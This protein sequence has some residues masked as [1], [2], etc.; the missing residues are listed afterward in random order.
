MSLDGY[1]SSGDLLRH[2]LDP[3]IARCRHALTEVVVHGPGD[4]E[5]IARSLLNLWLAALSDDDAQL[6]RPT[7]GRSTR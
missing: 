6:A 4:A 3:V 2:A 7:P 1:L 5:S